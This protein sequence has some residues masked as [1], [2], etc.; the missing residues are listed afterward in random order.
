MNK[1]K[2][3][4][5]SKIKWILLALFIILFLII[6]R[7]LFHDNLHVIDNTIYN[8][9]SKL[10]SDKVTIFFKIITNFSSALTL[11]LIT[12]LTLALFKNKKYGKF[13]IINLVCI[14]ILN[15]ILKF[16]FARTRPLDIMLIKETGYSFPSGHSMASMGFYGF[17]IYLIFKNCKNKIHKIIYISLLILLILLIGISRVY[18]G[19]HYASDVIA[20]F[21]ITISYLIIYTTIIS[22]KLEIER[23]K[24]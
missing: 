6:V 3:I 4:L 20:G 23:L 17:I 14:V 18:L 19:V 21:S 24:K 11:I 9:I 22:S 7:L 16:S 5:L 15:Q 13:M 10:K 2:K 1:I 12:L 8:V